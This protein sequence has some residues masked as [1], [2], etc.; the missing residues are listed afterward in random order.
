MLSEQINCWPNEEFGEIIGESGGTMIGDS[1]SD[2]SMSSSP[3]LFA[4]CVAKVI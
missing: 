2:K 4:V 3:S 1:P